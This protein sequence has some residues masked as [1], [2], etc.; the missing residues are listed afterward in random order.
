MKKLSLILLLLITA[1]SANVIAQTAP[2]VTTLSQYGFSVTNISNTDA[3]S[4]G[5]I[6]NNGGSEITAKGVVWSTSSSPTVVLTTKTNQGSG[7]NSPNSANNFYSYISGLTMN[8]TYYLRA[9]ATNAYGT[10][11][12]TEVTFKTFDHAPLG[13]GQCYQGGIIA[14]ILLPGDPGYTAGFTKGIIVSVSDQG[15]YAWGCSGTTTGATSSLLGGGQS[16][17]TA[18]V[19]ACTELNTAAKI[20]DN[21]NM[22]GYSDWYLPSIGDMVKLRTGL[23]LSNSGLFL[24]NFTTG[25]SYFTST[26]TSSTSAAEFYISSGANGGIS[27]SLLFPVRAIRSF[28]KLLK[29]LKFTVVYATNSYDAC[30]NG[31]TVQIYTADLGFCGCNYPLQSCWPCLTTSQNLYSDSLL[32]TIVA[33]GFYGTNVGGTASG[34]ANGLGDNFDKRWYV[35]SGKP[36]GYDACLQRTT[37]VTKSI[38]NIGNNNAI[39]GGYISQLPLSHYYLVNINNKGIVWDTSPNPTISL[40]TKTNNG[41]DTTN[42][43]GYMSNLSPNTTYYVR[44]YVNTSVGIIY[45]EEKSFT[46]LNN[47]PLSVG[48]AYQGGIIAYL[49]QPGDM[50][51]DAVNVK[52]IIAV[53][54]LIVNGGIRWHNGSSIQIGNTLTT[55]GSG[56]SNTASII[57][58]Q[59]SGSYAAKFCDDFEYEGYKDWFLP[60]KDE[61]NKVYQNKAQLLCASCTQVYW[62]SSEDG[63]LNVW[64]QGFNGGTQN[65]GTKENTHQVLAIRAITKPSDTISLKFSS[66]TITFP[67]QTTIAINSNA[68][69]TKNIIAYNFKFNYNSSKFKFDSVS[70]INT[71]SAGG[72]LQVNSAVNGSVNLGWARTTKL[73]GTQP[74]INLYFT[75][76]D[77]GKA[78]FTLSNAYL[79]A[80]SVTAL[81]SKS[82]IT[83]YNFGDIDLN[84]KILAYDAAL[85]LQYSVGMDPI[86]AIDPLPWEPWRIKIA[87]VDTTVAV[88]ANDAS[89]ILKYS[90]GIITK[91]PKR[92]MSSAPGYITVNLENNELVV[93]SFEDMGG[94]NI[95]FLDHLSDLGAPTYVH[96]T[97]ALSAFNKQANM[98]KIGVAFSEAPVNGTVILRIPY[99]GLGNQTLNMELVENTAARNYQLNVLTGINDIKN[100]NIKIYPNP[101]NNII[102]IEGLNKNENNAIQIFDVQGKLVITKTITEKGTLD[103]S[104]LN[105]GVYVIKIGEVAQRIVKM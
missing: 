57:N 65:S 41:S 17:T 1:I 73:T 6:V 7:T 99:T 90:V 102:N 84:K 96:S 70:T 23:Y 80:D 104:E 60:S 75:P 51:Y 67:S 101:T 91:F 5:I 36:T 19:N 72:T 30:W 14:H 52:G 82:I 85:A 97:N 74:I 3:L 38:T 48:Q 68:V 93:R 15:N 37:I 87:S 78:N 35:V 24:G 69:N 95:T 49:L 61:L 26:E 46:T 56:L 42:F 92:G 54:Q 2:T 58:A 45:G 40:T 83:K 32:T 22:N 55:L 16:N 77:S 28:S 9:Y 18:A 50:G 11:Y 103:L 100:S 94:L 98:Y 39:S 13:V 88:N 12:G 89:L 53:P 4:G 105:K 33:D 31:S 71:A 81:S 8:T 62:S 47:A 43:I 20:C 29:P 76:I 34:S 21:L 44:A 79:N 25:S 10:S 66:D 59:G 86:P 27:K 63:N 64:R